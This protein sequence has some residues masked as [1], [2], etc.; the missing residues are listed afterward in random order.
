M[1]IWICV[2]GVI[3]NWVMLGLAAEKE[4][5]GAMGMA[6]VIPFTLIPFLF[7]LLFGLSK[8]GDYFGWGK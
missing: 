7:V 3:L 6:M 1:I 5:N 4:P 2:L 8:I